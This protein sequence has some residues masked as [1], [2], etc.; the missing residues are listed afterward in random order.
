MG[1]TD[2]VDDGGPPGDSDECPHLVTVD[3]FQ[4]GKYE[5]TQDDWAKI[6]GD[7]PSFFTG[8]GNCPV[9]QVSWD[10]VQVFI[11]KLNRRTGKH[12]RLPSEEEWEFAARGSLKSSN[13]RYAGS[14][15]AADVA[16]HTVNSGGKPHAVGTLK[17]NEI[18]LFDM[19]GN[20][21]EWC[22]QFKEPYPCDKTGRHFD[23][24]IVRGGM[25][26]NHE[27]SVRVRDRNGRPSSIRINTI[28]LRLAT[29][30][31]R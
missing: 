17:P 4:I 3:D 23:S 27:S 12:Y 15:H 2:S 26:A 8:C 20:V 24:R 31:N 28:G 13:F 7:H 1:G 10:D 19:S 22:E 21:S 11:R 18:G 6:L 29:S 9:E 16:W 30:I 14:N 5:V 25:F